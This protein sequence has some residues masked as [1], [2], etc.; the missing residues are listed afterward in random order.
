MTQKQKIVFP[1]EAI[2]TEEEYSAGT[3]A[4]AQ[5]GVIKSS[6]TGEIILDD[7]TKEAS[8]RGKKILEL[9]RGDTVTGKVMLVKESQAVIELLSAENNKKITGVKTAQLPVRNV[10][11]EYITELKKII[12]VGDIVRA[13]IDSISP[14]AIDLITNEKGLGIIKAYCTNCRK[15]MEYS[16]QKLMCINCGSIEER[17]WFEAEQK[18][19]E[20]APRERRSFG[21]GFRGGHGGRGGFRGN[22]REGGFGARREGGFGGQREGGFNRS[23]FGENRGN[24]RRD[25]RSGGFGRRSDHTPRRDEARSFGGGDRY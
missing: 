19:R 22:R 2:T 23:R 14:L 7:T 9:E 15:E 21:G 1:G 13:K 11:T 6:T 24:F 12:K 10:S 3:N 5:N 25:D 16:N 8:V 18:A 17:K 20:F 4:F